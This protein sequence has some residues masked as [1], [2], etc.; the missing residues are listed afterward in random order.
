M[1]ILASFSTLSP[2]LWMRM[3]MAMLTTTVT[4]LVIVSNRHLLSQ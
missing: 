2:G 3:F 1:A 4:A